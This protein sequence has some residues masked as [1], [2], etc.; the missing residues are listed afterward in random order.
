M[1][2]VVLLILFVVS[3]WRYKILAMT[4]LWYLQEMDCPCPT[5]E[6]VKKGTEFV[7]R[8]MKKDLFEKGGGI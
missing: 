1:I 5:E 2:L 6:Q 8:H 7:I 3:W 4:L